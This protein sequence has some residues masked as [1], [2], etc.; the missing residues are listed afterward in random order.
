MLDVAIKN[1]LIEVV[2]ILVDNNPDCTGSYPYHSLC[3][4]KYAIEMYK[5]LDGRIA[6]K[7]KQNEK[8][9]TPLMLACKI[10]LV[11]AEKLLEDNEGM[12]VICLYYMQLHC[13]I[14]NLSL[15]SSSNSQ[16]RGP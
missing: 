8:G 11:L 9:C 6:G 7:T 14:D 12:Y 2:K 4:S 3:Y 10:N 13:K 16:C 15:Y 5:I 1:G